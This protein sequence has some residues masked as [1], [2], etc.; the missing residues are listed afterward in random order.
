[1]KSKLNKIYHQ[2]FP[3]IM[4]GILASLLIITGLLIFGIYNG[5]VQRNEMQQGQNI[6][7]K[8]DNV[9]MELRKEFKVKQDK[10]LK[11]SDELM[12]LMKKQNGR[13][14]K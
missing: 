2:Y 14:T 10:A 11:S 8:N 13:S 6:L 12:D 1:M 9:A 5:T 3:E 4:T 7:L